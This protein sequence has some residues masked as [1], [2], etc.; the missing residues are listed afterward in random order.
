MNKILLILVPAT[1]V[2][3]LLYM[4]PSSTEFML[5]QQH[6]PAYAQVISQDNNNTNTTAAT[7]SNTTITSTDLLS[8]VH[9]DID[10]SPIAVVIIIGKDMQ[11]N[12]T[13]MP[14]NATLNVGEEI[15][16][17]NNDT[18]FQSMTNGMSP[19]DPLAGKLF[20]TGPIPP[21]GFAEYVA[22][23]LSPGNYTFYSTNSTSTK[24][25]LTIE[26]NS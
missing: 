9:P 22:S 17:V 13:Y 19:D 3:S 5:L 6:K 8:S 23:N 12:I 25:V 14:N 15:L 4:V 20:D 1:L 18:N 11:G 26:P 2:L 7:A 10:S 21:R 16:V 24:G